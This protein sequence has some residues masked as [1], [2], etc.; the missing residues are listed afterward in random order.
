MNS[1]D[2]PS[3]PRSQPIRSADDD[4]GEALLVPPRVG[5]AALLSGANGVRS[6]ALVGGVALHAINV[7]IA[8]TILPSVVR[9]IGGLDLYA[10]NTTVFVVAS[11]MVI[12]SPKTGSGD[13]RVFR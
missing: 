12:C 8:T 10:W 5:W 3:E 6:L 13:V 1:R 9:D 11:I 2:I 4:T 7:Y